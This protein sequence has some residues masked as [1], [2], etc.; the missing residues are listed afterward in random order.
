MD[1]TQTIG[2][3]IRTKTNKNT[4]TKRKLMNMKKKYSNF[5]LNKIHKVKRSLKR[6]NE[7]GGELRYSRTRKYKR[8]YKLLLISIQVLAV[9]Y[10]FVLSAIQLNTFTNA[11][12]NDIEQVSAS[13]HVKWPIDEWDKSSLDFDPKGITL[14][15]GGTCGPPSNIFA[16][17]YN[18]GEDMT[19]STW[20]WELFKVGEGN[21][22]KTPIG[23]ALDIGEVEMIKAG[24]I[25]TIESTATII[26]NG[27]YRF[28]VTKP[29]RPGQEVIWSEAI[30]I[31]NCGKAKSQSI[32]TTSENSTE[33]T[34]KTETNE[35][36]T[37][38]KTED[39]EQVK[40]TEEND[41]SN[42]QNTSVEEDTKEENDSNKSLETNTEE[43]S[44][45]DT[46]TTQSQSTTESNSQE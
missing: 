17:I 31:K 25:G 20:K 36:P 37:D 40:Q 46:N 15:R 14:N 39:T 13:L 8:K 22:N 7:E 6:T 2:S 4:K 45:T 32:E 33:M 38:I 19:F 18:D 29:D 28:K 30:E 16:Q 12:F 41:Y 3:V 27:N 43:T 10:F 34:E 26:E 5:V 35:S 44:N 9:W 1:Y 11:A 42:N 21:E 23:E 24:E